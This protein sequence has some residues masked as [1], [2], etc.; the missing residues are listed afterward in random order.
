MGGEMKKEIREVE[1][2]AARSSF[3][4]KLVIIF[5]LLL[6]LILGGF[7]LFY[8]SQEDAPQEEANRE[9]QELTLSENIISSHISKVGPTKGVF[10]VRQMD[11]IWNEIEPSKGNFD[12]TIMDE[13]VLAA[14]EAEIYPSI[15]IQ[16][17]ANWDQ[18]TCH[19]EDKYLAPEENKMGPERLRMG[20]PCNMESYKMFLAKA[21]E[22]YDGD[23]IDDMPSLIRPLKYWEVLNEPIM[24]GGSTGGAGE[25]LKFFVGTNQ[26]YLATLKASYQAIKDADPNSYVL[27][28]GMAGMQDEVQE[29][30]GPIYK[31]AGKYFDI[32]NNHTISTDEDREDLY[33]VKFNQ[34]L[35]KYGNEDK[36]VWLTE[37]QFGSLT[38][39]P[40][41]IEEIDKLMVKSTVLSFALGADKLFYIPN[42][43]YW[44]EGLPGPGEEPTPKE[45]DEN[46]VLGEEDKKM[47]EMFG[48]FK[49][50][51]E[52]V[53]NSSTHKAYLNIVDKLN[54][55][56][57]VVTLKQEYEELDDNYGGV[58]SSIGQYKFIKDDQ[59]KIYV[60]WGKTKL[61]DDISDK[62]NYIVTD[63]Y[64]EQTTTTGSK[65]SGLLSDEPIFVE[66]GELDIIE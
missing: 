66:L 31:E 58:Q 49:S 24:Q 23:G 4:S 29:F 50:M 38:E 11:L 17:F 19:P 26:E 21:V 30:W 6:I 41:N 28:A 2:E 22:R 52:E 12:F 54:H 3:A 9:T 48:E 18:E 55:F 60:F 14:Q 10:W 64:G 8:R 15:L 36:P 32:A 34:F 62:M 35:E 40:E 42:W 33:M 16:P 56:D 59:S 44:Q 37:V 27:H 57:E 5:I 13:K 63:I 7:F 51:S 1:Q 45:N 46:N 43:I 65:I 53:E 25:E 61:P 47:G 20:A 39:Q